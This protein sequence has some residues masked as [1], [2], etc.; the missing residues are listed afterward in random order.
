MKRNVDQYF[1]EN[2]PYAGLGRT[3][4]RG[5]VAFV[6]ARG[7]NIIVQLASTILLAR[8]L[9]PHDFGLVTMVLALVGFAPMLIDLGTTDAST[10]KTRIT[11][12]EIST[13]FWLN[14]AIGGALDF[15]PCRRQRVHRV[16][17]W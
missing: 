2:K 8:L 5:G 15:T 1:E 17:F 10:Q 16:L 12:V 14:I 6:V 11:P 9:S 7:V 13:L 4:L 3:S